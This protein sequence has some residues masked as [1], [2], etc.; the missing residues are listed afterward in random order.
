MGRR[1]IIKVTA[2]VCTLA[3]P[4]VCKPLTVFEGDGSAACFVSPA[5]V[6]ETM[7]QKGLLEDWRLQGWSCT[8]GQRLSP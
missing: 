3:L 2:I 1:M 8:L 4:Q 5:E 7:K 6:A